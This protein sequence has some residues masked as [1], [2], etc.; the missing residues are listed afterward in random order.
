MAKGVAG[1]LVMPGGTASL[2]GE[3]RLSGTRPTSPTPKGRGP[4]GYLGEVKVLRISC[5]I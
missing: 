5:P 2:L 3:R 4:S 1:V